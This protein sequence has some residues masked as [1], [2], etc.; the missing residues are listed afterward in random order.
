MTVTLD[1]HGVRVIS[2]SYKPE[3]L[4]NLLL[5]VFIKNQLQ[6]NKPFSCDISVLFIRL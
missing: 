5:R 1:L 3:D 4:L 6:S 2:N